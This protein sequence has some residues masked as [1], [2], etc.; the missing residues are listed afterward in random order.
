M[1]SEIGGNWVDGV[2][3]QSHLCVVDNTGQQLKEGKGW[4]ENLLPMI[5]IILSALYVVLAPPLP[6]PPTLHSFVL[7]VW[8]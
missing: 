6:L 7:W 2:R 8:P 4:L 1:V 5:T 3:D